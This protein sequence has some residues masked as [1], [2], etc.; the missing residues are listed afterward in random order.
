MNCV[1]LF[2]QLSALGLVCLSASTI[3]HADTVTVNATDSVYSVTPALLATIGGTA[4]T[5]INILPGTTYITFSATGSVSV[6]GGGNYNNAD[7]IGS[8]Q[9]EN[10]DG[11]GSLS[12]IN[13]P[14][15]GYIAGVFLGAGGPSGSAPAGLDFG[16]QVGTSFL[17]LSPLLDQVF[18]VGDGLMNGS[19]I[20]I[21]QKFYVPT[22]AT[23]L[24]L[25]LAD[26]CGYSGPPSCLTDNI[27]SFQVTYNEV[28]GAP[29]NPSP[30]PEPSSFVL[31]GSG[32]LG[33]AGAVRRR[34]SSR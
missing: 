10:N 18:F 1:K 33:A 5:A 6:N 32:V 31:L 9:F 13:S 25:G 34:F 24:Y 28:G 20:L 29:V 11:I 16:G 17:S 7:G 30:V 21:T 2:S 3:A 8:V 15:A 26:A 4:P 22:G 19:N 23:Q 12:G 27:G 14:T